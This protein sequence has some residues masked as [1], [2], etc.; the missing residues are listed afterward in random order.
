MV[1]SLLEYSIPKFED[2]IEFRSFSAHKSKLFNEIGNKGWNAIHASIVKEQKELV[3][4]FIKKGGDF[5]LP[6]IGGW[7]P[8]MLAINLNNIES[9]LIF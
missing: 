6:T 1:K 9:Y 8:L 5:N 4:F 3:L 7:S 2:E